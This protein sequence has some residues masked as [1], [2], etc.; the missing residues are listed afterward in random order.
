MA[1]VLAV[2]LIP[3]RAEAAVDCGALVPSSVAAQNLQNINSCLSGVDQRAV[4]T[5]GTYNVDGSIVV[6]SGASLVGDT[7]Y[8]TIRLSANPSGAV[9]LVRFT[10]S[11]A[12]VG[13]VRLDAANRLVLGCCSAVVMFEGSGNNNLL[14]DAFVTGAPETTGVYVLCRA[15]SGNQ[16]LRVEIHSNFYGVIFGPYNDS[17]HANTIVDSRLHDNRCDGVTFMGTDLSAGRPGGFGVIEGSSLYRNGRDCENGIPG[18]AV[19]TAGNKAGGRILNS[20]LYDNCGNNLDMVDSEHF[21]I[22]GN[23]I[24]NPGF[25]VPG[26]AYYCTG[27][28]SGAVVNI[29]ETAFLRNTFRNTNP[30]TVARL[31]GD[32]NRF[33][34][35]NGAALYSDLPGG[36]NGLVAFVLASW[37]TGTPSMH[38]TIEGNSFIGNCAAPCV[39]TGYFTS[40]GTGFD[41][42]HNWSAATTNYFRGNNPFGSNVGSRRGGGNWYAADSTCTS[43]S[44]PFPCN[45]DDYQHPTSVNWARNDGFYFY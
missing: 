2:V 45:V 37:R 15:C 16:M 28:A 18:A 6:P 39:G 11:G 30:R 19:Y 41:A 7:T 40:R 33:F 27:T 36:G 34:N 23:N 3:G 32:P 1:V 12:R 20:Q 5:P 17:A 44:S 13:F 9:R 4:L 38:N 31:H 25:P 8:P 29:R 22:E 14:D 10:G 35:A 42:A 43:A 24:Y 21:H 26:A